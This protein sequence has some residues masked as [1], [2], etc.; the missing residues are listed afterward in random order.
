M[1]KTPRQPRLGIASGSGYHRTVSPSQWKSR[2]KFLALLAIAAF[3]IACSGSSTEAPKSET[4]SVTP[5]PTVAQEKTPVPRPEVTPTEATASIAPTPIAPPVEQPEPT[6]LAGPMVL[7]TPV[8]TPTPPQIATPVPLP[9]TP[10]PAS[11]LASHLFVPVGESRDISG[12]GKLVETISFSDSPTIEVGPNSLTATAPGQA[13]LRFEYRNTPRE[14]SVQTL[15]VVSFDE[16]GACT[17]LATAT[18]D[19]ETFL[20]AEGQPV[21]NANLLESGNG[22]F[23]AACQTPGGGLRLQQPDVLLPTL[24]FTI[25]DALTDGPYSLGTPELAWQRAGAVETYSGETIVPPWIVTM[26]IDITDITVAQDNSV[27]FS[28]GP[29]NEFTPSCT[30]NT[31]I[32]RPGDV[33]RVS[34]P[35]LSDFLVPVYEAMTDAQRDRFFQDRIGIPWTD[36]QEVHPDAGHQAFIRVGSLDIM[37]ALIADFDGLLGVRDRGVTVAYDQSSAP[38]PFPYYCFPDDISPGESERCSR[39]EEAIE[40]EEARKI[41]ELL[42]AGYDLWFAATLRPVKGGHSPMSGERPDFSLFNGVIARIEAGG[43]GDEAGLP[44]ALAQATRTFAAE[45]GP[46]MPLVLTLAGP[47]ITSATGGEFCEAEICASDFRGMYEQ[48]EAVFGAA[49]DSLEP[50]QLMGFGIATFEGSHF[51]IRQP[52][53]DFE[54]LELNRVGETGYNNPVLN[55]YRAR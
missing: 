52:Y 47:P 2:W 32:L 13:C 25:V 45:L 17:G 55:I 14:N 18:L 53:E 8:P 1:V 21:G 41:A 4:A 29:C 23:Y 5:S 7:P 38:L 46:D 26:G 49:L 48:T 42:A 11:R 31:G 43:N 37:T 15:C 44:T 20:E 40:A 54:G 19:L 39:I 10:A 16:T 3:F 28:A 35:T 24:Y 6:P 34:P 36:F 30:E 22:R 51:D 27:L 9:P 33:L 50:G 12:L